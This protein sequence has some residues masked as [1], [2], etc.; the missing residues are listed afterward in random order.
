MSVWA[1]KVCKA[2]ADCDRHTLTVLSPDADTRCCPTESSAVT[3]KVC[4]AKC[5][6]T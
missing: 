1:A 6:A 2:V 4:P 3:S 5:P